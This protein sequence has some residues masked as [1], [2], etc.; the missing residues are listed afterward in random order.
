MRAPPS[1]PCL[2]PMP[3]CAAIFAQERPCARRRSILARPTTTRVRPSRFPLARAIPVRPSR[4]VRGG[5]T[6]VW[7]PC[8]SAEPPSGASRVG[9]HLFDHGIRF[10][11]WRLRTSRSKG[12][13]VYFGTP[14]TEVMKKHDHHS[15][16]FATTAYQRVVKS[17]SVS[18]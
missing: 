11:S 10:V 4:A 13:R 7:R 18:H 16:S 3:S 17:A 5:C 2:P 8:V 6:P 14:R 9:V 12:P 15:G 1:T